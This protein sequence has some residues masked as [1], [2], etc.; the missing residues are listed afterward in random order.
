V[1]SGAYGSQHF[2]DAVVCPVE[3]IGPGWPLKNFAGRGSRRGPGALGG[4][5]R[6]L[7]VTVL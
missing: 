5:R 6:P 7:R 2:Q 3:G 4:R 1:D